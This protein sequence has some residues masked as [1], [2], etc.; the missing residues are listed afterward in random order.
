MG[1][2]EFGWMGG[3]GEMIRNISRRGRGGAGGAGEQPG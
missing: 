2:R 1:K 3:Q